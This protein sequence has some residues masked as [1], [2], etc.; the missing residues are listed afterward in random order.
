MPAPLA[1][2][3]AGLALGALALPGRRRRPAVAT[4]ASAPPSSTWRPWTIEAG[5]KVSPAVER[6]L[7]RLAADL[8][9]VPIYVTDGYRTAEDQAAAMWRKKEVEGIDAVHDLYADDSQVDAIFAA[10]PDVAAMATVIRAY[11]ARG[12]AI[13]LHLAPSDPE[14]HGAAD[15]RTRDLA[16]GA[17]AMLQSAAIARGAEAKI[18][19]DH[20][21]LEV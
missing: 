5:E 12:Q 14:S 15:V 17:A 11:A 10:G 13:S 21:H 3:A 7:D 2:I 18:E 19:S 1:V 9:D 6:L 8:P 16:P 20:L 4:V